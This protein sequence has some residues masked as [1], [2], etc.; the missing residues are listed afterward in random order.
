MALTI[1][2]K[3][4]SLRFDIFLSSP[5]SFP[6]RIQHLLGIMTPPPYYFNDS[7]R[8][9]ASLDDLSFMLVYP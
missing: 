9:K 1:F 5:F 2:N 3:A 8:M 4:F 7:K 6:S